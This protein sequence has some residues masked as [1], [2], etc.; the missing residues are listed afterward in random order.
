MG[1]YAKSYSFSKTMRMKI[2]I[3]KKYSKKNN[4]F[5]CASTFMSSSSN[6]NAI[7]SIKH[8]KTNVDFKDKIMEKS[9]VQE[10]F[11]P[12]N[13]K[14]TGEVQMSYLE[15]LEELRERVLLAGA[16]GIFA[17]LICFCFSKELV[18]F[19]E[20]PVSDQYV[21]FFQMTPGEFF[22]TTLKVSG[23]TGL[24]VAMPTILYQLGAWLRPGLTID[25]KEILAPIFLSSTILFLFGIFFSYKVLAPSALNFF[26]SYANG[27]VESLWSIDQYFEFILVLMLSTGLSFQLPIVQFLIGKTGIINSDQMF[28]NWRYIV[29]CATILSAFLTPS[30]DPLTQILLTC[31]LIGLYMGSAFAVRLFEPK[32]IK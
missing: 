25:E 30:T 20:N 13:D 12:A 14:L 6:I 15:H 32:D 3:S 10:F 31:P 1:M 19:L 4:K 2:D 9:A 21:R 24:L 26:V 7:Y 8:I 23:Y 29:L 28:S 27:A 11:F 16:A 22:F 5:N 17:V 18:I